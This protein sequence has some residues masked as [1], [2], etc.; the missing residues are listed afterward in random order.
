VSYPKAIATQRVHVEIIAIKAV[1]IAS[2]RPNCQYSLSSSSSFSS[3]NFYIWITS[4]VSSV[5]DAALGVGVGVCTFAHKSGDCV[6]LLSKAWS[7]HS[8]PC[9]TSQASLHP[10][11]AFKFPSSHCS[12]KPMGASTGANLTPS[13]QMTPLLS[14]VQW[15]EQPS[16]L[17]RL[18]SSHSS[19]TSRVPSPHTAGTAGI[20]IRVHTSDVVALPPEHCHPESIAHDVHPSLATVLPSSHSFYVPHLSPFP[21]VSSRSIV[22]VISRTVL[23][24]SAVTCTVTD[25]PDNY[26]A[27]RVTVASSALPVYVAAILMV[28]WMLTTAFG[29]P[30]CVY[31]LHVDASKATTTIY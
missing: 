31:I 13:P 29:S 26:V 11:P 20:G 30:G 25:I 8:H 14:I 6:G 16:S 27:S 24:L 19:G 12:S 17:I 7:E 10:S 5:T 21:Q 4:G 18:P 28:D 3:T 23:V 15:D 9:S 2:R 1:R 22:Y